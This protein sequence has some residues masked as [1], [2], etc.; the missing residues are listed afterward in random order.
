[1]YLI[2]L[3]FRVVLKEVSLRHLLGL[4]KNTRRLHKQTE[5]ERSACILPRR[6][7]ACRL[8][9][10]LFLF[11]AIHSLLLNTAPYSAH[12]WISHQPPRA[13]TITPK[14]DCSVD[15]PEFDNSLRTHGTRNFSDFETRNVKISST[16]SLSCS[17][18]TVVLSQVFKFAFNRN[19]NNTSI[20][21][22]LFL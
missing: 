6:I 9:L 12:F 8:L 17:S 11:T 4:L 15:P 16:F 19:E 1:M 2:L 13:T 14:I 7:S 3:N 18:K 5:Q 20:D 22:L 21:G 10:Y